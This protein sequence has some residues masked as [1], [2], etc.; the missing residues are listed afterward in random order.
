MIRFGLMLAFAVALAG[1]TRL[2]ADPG[3]R[4]VSAYQCLPSDGGAAAGK[5]RRLTVLYD[6]RGQQALISLDGGSI[7][8]LNLVPDV[9]ERLFANA[10]YAWK[11]NGDTNQLTDL[12]EV[13]TYSC[14]RSADVAAAAGPRP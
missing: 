9:K 7:N 6:A 4:Q 8:Y 3:S 1:C 10:K 12:A 11:S 2:G 5:G 13:Q 14:T